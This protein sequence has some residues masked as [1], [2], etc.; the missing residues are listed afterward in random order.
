MVADVKAARRFLATRSDVSGRIGI[1][2]PRSAPTSRRWRPPTI[3]RVVSLALLSP[4]LDYRGLRIEPAMRKIG[5]R[6]VLMVASDDDPYATRT[7]R[8]LEK[9]TEGRE[10]MHLQA[11]R[12]R[13][14]DARPRAGARRRA[15]GLVSPDA[16][17]ILG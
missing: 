17:M 2:G 16:V 15:G 4:S 10:V 14:D 12:A 5:S 3:R 1:S 6:P 13:H 11:R 8:D 7:A 9:G